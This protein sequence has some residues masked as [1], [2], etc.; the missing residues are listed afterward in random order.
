M[1]Q[2]ILIVEDDE[3]IVSSVRY[4]LEREGYRVLAAY[5]GEEGLAMARAAKPDLV[6]LD[7]MMPVM[8]GLQCV[9][10]LRAE[11]AVPV[12]MLTARGEE[13]DRVLGLEL[14]ADDYVVK[15]FGMRELVARIRAQLRRAEMQTRPPTTPDNAVVR[16]G[17]LTFDRNRHV[18]SKDDRPVDLR[19]K[20]YDLLAVLMTHAGHA[21]ERGELLDA[22]WGV[23][24]IGDPRTLDVHIRWLRQ[25]IEDDPATPRYILTVRGLG[26]RFVQAEEVETT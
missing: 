10:T 25:K 22:V 13:V 23:G 7:V 6:L 9:R 17:R 19:P 16:I 26:Y 20:E 1:P 15:P 11:S 2:T 12:I 4:G 24:W 3:L 8:D 18:V 14:G 21:F 5:N